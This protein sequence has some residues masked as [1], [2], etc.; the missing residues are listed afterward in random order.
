MQPYV[1]A[2][3]AVASLVGWQTHRTRLRNL[4]W[5]YKF[6]M[7]PIVG[8]TVRFNYENL[9]FLQPPNREKLS[10]KLSD[11]PGSAS[12]GIQSWFSNIYS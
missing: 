7:G 6:A 3:L 2:L 1:L 4:F 9:N 12:K 11:H 5:R 8:F 10:G